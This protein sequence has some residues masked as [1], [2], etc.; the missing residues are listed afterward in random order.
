[1]NITEIDIYLTSY[2]SHMCYDFI[3]SD[4][5]L[6]DLK[7]RIRA[8]PDTQHWPSGYIS[9]PYSARSGSICSKIRIQGVQ[10]VMRIWINIMG[11]SP[12][13]GLRRQKK[14]KQFLNGKYLD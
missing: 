6:S 9:D 4:P 7:V 1:M 8:D 12:G 3:W 2:I 11:C 13:P 10:L 5:E 14:P